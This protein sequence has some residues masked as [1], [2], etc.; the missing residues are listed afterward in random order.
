[1]IEWLPIE[2]APKNGTV[3]LLAAMDYYSLDYAKVYKDKRLRPRVSW[4]AAKFSTWE[5]CWRRIYDGKDVRFPDFFEPH[6]FAII[7]DVPIKD[8]YEGR[9]F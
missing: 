5:N 1:M 2:H 7:N 9:E 6:A 3:V 8:H 4:F